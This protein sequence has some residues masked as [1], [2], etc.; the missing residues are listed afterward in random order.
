[1]LKVFLVC[2]SFAIVFILAV[3]FSFIVFGFVFLAIHS[4]SVVKI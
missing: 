3:S 2:I 1:L 4:Y